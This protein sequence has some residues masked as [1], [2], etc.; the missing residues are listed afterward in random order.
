MC[1]L[2]ASVGELGDIV[3]RFRWEHPTLPA[4]TLAADVDTGWRKAVRAAGLWGSAGSEEHLQDARI[5]VAS[6]FN[7]YVTEVRLKDKCPEF[8]QQ[9]HRSFRE[10]HRGAYGNESSWDLAR[11]EFFGY[12]RGNIAEAQL[13]GMFQSPPPPVIAHHWR[14]WHPTKAQMQLLKTGFQALHAKGLVHHAAACYKESGVKVLA[15]VRA[16]DTEADLSPAPLRLYD[17]QNPSLARGHF[18]KLYPRFAVS[19]HRSHGH[20]CTNTTTAYSLDS[21]CH[22]E[23]PTRKVVHSKHAH[24]KS[25]EAKRLEREKYQLRGGLITPIA[26]VWIMVGTALAYI[27][28]WL[29]GRACQFYD[30]RRKWEQRLATPESAQRRCAAVHQGLAGEG[31]S[32]YREEKNLLGIP[33]VFLK[34]TRYSDIDRQGAV[35]ATGNFHSSSSDFIP[36]MNPLMGNKGALRATTHEPML[37][38]FTQMFSQELK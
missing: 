8:L 13:W 10:P 31:S 1:I 3:F 30:Y 32:L 38:A 16:V 18:E 22:G 33:A 23:L 21:A 12:S 27:L 2:F 6:D 17:A 25:V 29:G 24:F 35:P 20:R 11:L 9:L 26:M 7:L 28:A 14:P 34:G 4:C 15:V 5:A 37:S 19:L 36:G